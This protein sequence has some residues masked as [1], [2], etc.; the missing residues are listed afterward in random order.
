MRINSALTCCWLSLSVILALVT[1]AQTASKQANQLH[2]STSIQLLAHRGAPE[3][4]PEH[5]LPSYSL[6]MRQR[7]DYIEPDICLTSDGHAICMHDFELS[8]TTDVADHPEFASKHTTIHVPSGAYHGWFTNNFTLAEIK[9]LRVKQRL[10]NRDLYY[11]GLFE[12]PTLNET[13]VFLKQ[14]NAELGLNVGIYI[15]PKHPAYFESRGL[16]YDE[17]LIEV[18]KANGMILKHEDGALSKVII[19]CFESSQLQRLRP[20]MDVPFVQ[21]IKEPWEKADDTGIPYVEMM[22]KAGL[23]KI[24][25]YSNAIGP[26]KSYYEPQNE[27]FIQ[28]CNPDTLVGA[29]GVNEAHRQNLLIHPWTARNAWED[30]YI[31][32]YFNGS[33]ELQLQ[34]LF[35]LGIDGIFTESAGAA[36]CVRKAY[37]ESFN[38]PDVEVPTPSPTER[39]SSSALALYITIP[40]LCSLFT[41]LIGVAI[42]RYYIPHIPN[43]GQEALSLL[44]SSVQ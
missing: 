25:Q 44:N 11:D 16:R 32:T 9:T 28:R 20:H 43:R 31:P 1:V 12:V 3:F 40:L 39:P 18:L 24:A 2:G 10:R 21:L 26:I 22:N 41:G 15:E 34:Y 5:T 29:D 14:K 17:H 37:E 6:A 38:V 36:Y 23:E 7:V 19:E 33:E 13:L 42:G 30:P 35:D 4:I 27:A 8:A